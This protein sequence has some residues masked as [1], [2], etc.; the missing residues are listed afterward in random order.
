MIMMDV[1]WGRT[2]SFLYST[3]LSQYQNILVFLAYLLIYLTSSACGN[4]GDNS[5]HVDKWIYNPSTKNYS[6]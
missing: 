2:S 3:A 6:V 1:A 5:G 4:C